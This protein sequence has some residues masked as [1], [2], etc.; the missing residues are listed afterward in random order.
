MI[1]GHGAG[2]TSR[3]FFARA[4]VLTAPRPGAA[5]L[6]PVFSGS[7]SCP[8]IPRASPAP[9]FPFPQDRHRRL[10]RKLHARGIT[11]VSTGGT[12]RILVEAGLPVLG[13]LAG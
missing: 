11:L 8:P 6:L 13:S 2:S 12:H 7:R 4:F 3:F 10:R 1:C 9:C 5:A